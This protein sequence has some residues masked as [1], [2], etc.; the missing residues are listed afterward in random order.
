MYKTKLFET[1]LY[2]DPTTG[3]EP[4][5]QWLDALKDKTTKTRISVRIGRAEDGNFGDHRPLGEGLFELRFHHGPGYRI[6]YGIERGK[7]ILLLAGGDKSTQTKDIIK[8]K[9]FWESH[10]KERK[11]G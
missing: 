8:A 4:L 1:I 7:I 9:R 2:K 6:Y 11:N 5:T 3:K 10:Q